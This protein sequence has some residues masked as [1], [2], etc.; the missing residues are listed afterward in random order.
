MIATL[1]AQLRRAVSQ[2]TGVVRAVE[3]CLPT[4]AEAPLFRATADVAR[5]ACRGLLGMP[6][7]HLKV[8]CHERDRTLSFVR[9]LS[10]SALSRTG[11][12]AVHGT[13]TVEQLMNE[14][15]FHDLGHIRQIAEL[16]R[17]DL[18][19]DWLV[20]NARRHGVLPLLRRSLL[21]AGARIEP[22][23]RIKKNAAIYAVAQG[24]THCLAVLLPR[25]FR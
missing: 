22:V 10:P 25:F 21:A 19:W 20:A 5:D 15:A 1:P 11:V 13:I 24:C 3:E 16:F 23:D 8:F 17:D 2:Y 18:N 14:W 12:H 9:Y 6:L 4:T 7:E